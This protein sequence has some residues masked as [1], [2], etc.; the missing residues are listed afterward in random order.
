MAPQPEEL[1]F[2]QSLAFMPLLSHS[3]PLLSM[4][5]SLSRIYLTAQQFSYN[6]CLGL[7]RGRKVLFAFP[8][9]V[10]EGPFWS[11]GICICDNVKQKLRELMIFSNA[12]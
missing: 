4:T 9:F 5:R 3:H 10:H 7:L 8:D 11:F 12:K 2:L 6:S 1:A